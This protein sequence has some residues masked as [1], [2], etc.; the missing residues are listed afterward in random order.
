MD[1]SKGL[2]YRGI[3]DKMSETDFT[4]KDG[5]VTTLTEEK[6]IGSIGKNSEGKKCPIVARHTAVNQNEIAV[7]ATRK[8]MFVPGLEQGDQ[9]AFKRGA[10]ITNGMPIGF[11]GRREFL[12]KLHSPE[13]LVFHCP[14]EFEHWNLKVTEVGVHCL[15]DRPFPVEPGT[16][17]FRGVLIEPEAQLQSGLYELRSPM[18]G[19]FYR[20]PKPDLPEYVSEGSEIVVGVPLCVILINKVHNDI[21]SEVEGK[22]EN[23]LVESGTLVEEDQVLMRIRLKASDE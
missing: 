21:L 23:I 13:L 19:V 10:K 22:V 20:K 6:S 14:A 5:G 17:L 3:F 8:G 12:G 11:I 2:F 16:V 18:V 9:P 1:W 4:D 7:L 15:F